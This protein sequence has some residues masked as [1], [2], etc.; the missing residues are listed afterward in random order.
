[1]ERPRR[2]P[3]VHTSLIYAIS[4]QITSRLPDGFV[5]TIET[6]CPI[7]IKYFP[8]SLPQRFIR[9]A[10]TGEPGELVTII[11]VLSP[12]NKTVGN[13]YED[14]LGKQQLLLASPVN[15]L[16]IDLLRMGVPT[17]AASASEEYPDSTYTVSLHEAMA[18]EF[19]TWLIQL[20]EPLPQIL[21]PLKPGY[22]PLWL[23]CRRH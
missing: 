7:P 8:D 15:L 9:I 18:E 21:V 14:Y 17:V 4:T 13:G 12:A 22:A 3:D 1:L 10:L 5:S 11:E 20:R 2:W 6:D 16:E 19:I 23:V